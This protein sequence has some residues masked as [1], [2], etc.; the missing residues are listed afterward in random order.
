MGK[1]HTHS[2]T[3]I[4]TR[5]ARNRRVTVILVQRENPLIEISAI[6]TQY[7]RALNMRRQKMSPPRRFL[8]VSRKEATR[9]HPLAR[10]KTR[11]FCTFR[12]LFFDRSTTEDKPLYLTSFTGKI[13][14]K[15]TQKTLLAPSQ[16]LENSI[17][18]FDRRP[19]CPAAT[20]GCY[21]PPLCRRPGQDRPFN[22]VSEGC[23]KNVASSFF[24]LFIKLPLLSL[25]GSSGQVL[26]LRMQKWSCRCYMRL[27][28]AFF[29][30]SVLF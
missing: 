24:F 22:F 30:S 5:Q 9:I 20:T 21:G 18:R 12:N 3:S 10:T 11:S 2:P 23:S 26:S 14:P 19:T 6:L 29:F 8:E 16:R 1:L 25:R 27:S 17:S 13:V 28:S 15:P 7:D 4:Q